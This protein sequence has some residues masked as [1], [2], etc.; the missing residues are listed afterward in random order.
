MRNNA[1]NKQ[2]TSIEHITPVKIWTNMY[3]TLNK[4]ASNIIISKNI[5]YYTWYEHEITLKFMINT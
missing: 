5:A 3:R 1:K 4:R 2:I